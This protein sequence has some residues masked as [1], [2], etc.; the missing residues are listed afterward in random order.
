[1][2][3]C[4]RPQKNAFS[5]NEIIQEDDDE[6][7]KVNFGWKFFRS[8]CHLI[9][10]IFRPFCS[11]QVAFLVLLIVVAYQTVFFA[12]L[13]IICN[14]FV[15][16]IAGYLAIEMREI[17]TNA[18]HALYFRANAY[19]VV[20]NFLNVDNPYDQRFVQDVDS[21]C[22]SFTSLAPDL[23][24]SPFVIAFYTYKTVDRAGWLG[25]VSIL[26]FFIVF[27]IINRFIVPWVAR[28]VFERERQEGYFRFLH[29]H[30]RLQSEQAAFSR[31]SVPEYC[32]ADC[33][34]RRLLAAQQTWTT[35]NTLLSCKY[36][37]STHEVLKPPWYITLHSHS[38]LKTKTVQYIKHCV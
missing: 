26:V 16:L 8:T 20:I 17:I 4:R 7:R 27:S 37:K 13:V 28:S 32:V 18:I 10:I 3:C 2:T 1:M 9:N 25:P 22:T 36:R 6:K 35:R 34:L 30:L 11:R 31:A 24:L 23:V 19:Y 38:F 33:S 14:A 12:I 29:A 5:K 15:S 21:L